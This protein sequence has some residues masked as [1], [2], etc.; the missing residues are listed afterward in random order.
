LNI[1]LQHNNDTINY[2]KINRLQ[3][4]AIRII[5][6]G[7]RSTP[8]QGNKIHRSAATENI[9]YSGFYRQTEKFIRLFNNPMYLRMNEL[10]KWRMKWSN[11]AERNKAI[12]ELSGEENQNIQKLF[13]STNLEQSWSSKEFPELCENI[14]FFKSN[15]YQRAEQRK[16]L[17]TIYIEEDGKSSTWTYLYTDGSTTNVTEDGNCR[18]LFLLSDGEGM[19]Q[20][21]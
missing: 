14:K 16:V 18:V 2:K 8:I 15:N 1:A 11:F 4:Q 10:G 13:I 7:V 12:K 5:A 9:R 17:T 19:K 3:N 6:G 21:W 20:N